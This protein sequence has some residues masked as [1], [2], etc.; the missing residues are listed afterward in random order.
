[1][2]TEDKKGSEK[3]DTLKELKEKYSEYQK[4]YYLPSFEELNKEFG[5]EK[6][7]KDTDFFLREIIKIVIDKFQNYMR[8][9]EGLINPSNA[10]IFVFSL[11]KL[12]DNGNKER[13][14]KAY[15]KISEIELKIISLDLES[16]EN[17]EAEFIKY[18]YKNWMEIK[19][20]LI[21]VMKFVEEN[22]DKKSEENKKNYFG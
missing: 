4:K 15:K 18:C 3:K 1:M 10:S 17:S 20:D 14:S 7:E 13:L 6:A 21:H 19:K 9:I 2:T 5:I 11:V 16:T 8:F 22:W 12:I